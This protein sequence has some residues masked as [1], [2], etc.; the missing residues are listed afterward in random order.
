MRSKFIKSLRNSVYAL[1]LIGFC[2]MVKTISAQQSNSTEGPWSLRFD[3][4]NNS[5][6]IPSEDESDALGSRSKTTYRNS[7]NF[8]GW[9]VEFGYCVLDT[10]NS[11]VL[12]GSSFTQTNLAVSYV[13]EYFGGK[14]SITI[15][16]YKLRI[17][18]LDISLAY[19]HKFFNFL[20]LNTT[21]GYSLPLT[22][23]I[24]GSEY[25]H[26]YE[27]PNFQ[28]ER[29]V[30]LVDNQIKADLYQSLYVGAGITLRLI[31]YKDVWL[32][33][34]LQYKRQLLMPINEEF[35]WRQY[36]FGVIAYF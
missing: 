34:T 18:L 27:I 33:P 7:P 19:H 25:T 21:V 20:Y 28:E 17:S 12:L 36:N 23:A 4:S 14:S 8:G 32:C 2:L 1:Q 10:I 5:I 35:N 29:E 31:K 11:K 22:H 15:A 26:D 9:G 16:D 24:K 13:K 6:V 3:Y 30:N